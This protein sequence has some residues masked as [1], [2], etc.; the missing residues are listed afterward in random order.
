VSGAIRPWQFRHEGP[1]T[2]CTLDVK[3]ESTKMNLLELVVFFEIDIYYPE[4]TRRFLSRSYVTPKST[5][6]F[7]P[8]LWAGYTWAAALEW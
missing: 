7:S 1:E 3:K 2:N 4:T 6:R 8:W 5:K